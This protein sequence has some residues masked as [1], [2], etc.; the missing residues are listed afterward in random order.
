MR[1]VND[2]QGTGKRARLDYTVVCGKTGTAQW[3]P[4]D[5]KKNLGWFTGFFPLDKPKYAFAMVYEGRP[6]EKVSGGSNAA[7]MVKS[8][9]GPIKDE[10]NF[11]IKPPVR[12][13]IVLEDEPEEEIEPEV[14]EEIGAPGRAMIVE[15][16]DELPA[17][18]PPA[19]R[20]MIVE[21]DEEEVDPELDRRAILEEEEQDAPPLRPLPD[22]FRPNGR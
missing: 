6:G 1:V 5:A 20:A 13:M 16:A 2:G 17:D 12:A 18:P 15:E 9:F 22:N 7:P 3:G 21:E 8:F 4:K 10:V 14:E 11:R 19:P